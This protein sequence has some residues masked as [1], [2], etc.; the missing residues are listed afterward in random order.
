MSESNAN[1]GLIG[2]LRRWL[3][4]DE[5]APAPGSAAGDEQIVPQAW[6]DAAQAAV[7]APPTLQRTDL[8]NA[9]QAEI[10]AGGEI[11]T[12]ALRTAML[13]HLS[14]ADLDALCRALDLD[15]GRL[16]G[17]KGR[18][19]MALLMEAQYAGKLPALLAACRARRPEIAW[20][21]ADG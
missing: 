7:G 11:D 14:P 16:N 21:P 10:A 12:V 19:T 13:N 20:Q 5:T 2:R 17:G 9:R 8:V 15:P 6:L 18:Q 4:G 3:G 1:N